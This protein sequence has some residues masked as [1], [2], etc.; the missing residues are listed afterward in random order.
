MR[1]IPLY[2]P[3]HLYNLPL[4]IYHNNTLTFMQGNLLLAPLFVLPNEFHKK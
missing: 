3:Y 2:L 1:Y 4:K